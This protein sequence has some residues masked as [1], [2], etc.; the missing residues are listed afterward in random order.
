MMMATRTTMIARDEGEDEDEGEDDG[1][2]DD[3]DDHD[4][5]GRTTLQARGAP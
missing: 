5:C 2:D 1:D 4:D 3:D